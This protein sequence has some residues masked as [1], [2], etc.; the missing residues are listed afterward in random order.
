LCEL[1]LMKLRND[2]ALLRKDINNLLWTVR[3]VL[4]GVIALLVRSFF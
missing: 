4:G 1:E 3:I 2:I